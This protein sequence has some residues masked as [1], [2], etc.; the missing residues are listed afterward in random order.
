[1][2]IIVAYAPVT[3]NTILAMGFTLTYNSEP[4]LMLLLGPLSRKLCFMETV[5]MF[6]NSITLFVWG[7]MNAGM[8]EVF[9]F[10]LCVSRNLKDLK[11][12]IWFVQ[13]QSQVNFSQSQIMACQTNNIS[14]YC[15]T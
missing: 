6:K 15:Y 9:C 12:I 4:C 3:I 7:L 10:C 8:D 14:Y 5:L 13:V 11:D 2:I 1:M